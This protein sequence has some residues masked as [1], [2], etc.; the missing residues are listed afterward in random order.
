MRDITYA[1]E[2]THSS[3]T[4]SFSN[5]ADG[6]AIGKPDTISGILLSA[7]VMIEQ[8]DTKDA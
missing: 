6:K 4:L 3:K 1:P 8:K 2:A 5:G 7:G